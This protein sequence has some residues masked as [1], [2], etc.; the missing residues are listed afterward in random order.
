MRVEVTVT[1][2]VQTQY[3]TVTHADA[4]RNRDTL[5]GQVGPSDGLLDLDEVCSG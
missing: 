1:R 2:T 3:K 4:G 5:R